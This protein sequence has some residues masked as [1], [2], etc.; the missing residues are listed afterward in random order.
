[1]STSFINQTPGIRKWHTSADA[2]AAYTYVPAEAALPALYSQEEVADPL[3]RVKLFNPWG[4]GYWFL[5]EWNPE[6]G[7]AFG[8][9]VIHEA[10]LGYVDLNELAA[11]RVGPGRMPIER[12]IHFAPTPLSQVRKLV[13][14]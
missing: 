11:L 4:Q 1:M 2:I 10:E 9:C 3:V 6:E 14:Q 13:N 5:T 8:L 12:D 7:L